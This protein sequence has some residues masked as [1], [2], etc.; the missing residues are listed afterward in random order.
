MSIRHTCRAECLN[1][2][3]CFFVRY[4]AWRTSAP[5]FVCTGRTLSVIWF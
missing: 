4:P 3:G 2:A 5:G 1:R